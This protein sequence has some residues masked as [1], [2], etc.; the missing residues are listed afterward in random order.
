MRSYSLSKCFLA[1][2]LQISL[3]KVIY[4]EFP[5][6]FQFVNF[7][8]QENISNQMSYCYLK[9]KAHFLHPRF[10]TMSSSAISFLDPLFTTVFQSS[11]LIPFSSSQQF[12]NPHFDS[13]LLSQVFHLLLY[14]QYS[15]PNTIIPTSALLILW[16]NFCSPILLLRFP[17]SKPKM[18]MNSFSSLYQFQK[19]YQHLL[20]KIITALHTIRNMKMNDAQLLPQNTYN[21]VLQIKT[22]NT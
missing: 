12:Y 3:R 16:Y 5:Y 7:H 1:V 9:P 21:L 17:I 6:S 2:K 19:M 13:S 11:Y 18:D 22:S 10:Q 4:S 14:I 8:H 15:N 20:E